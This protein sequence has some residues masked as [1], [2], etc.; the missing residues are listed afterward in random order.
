VISAEPAKAT[1][2]VNAWAVRISGFLFGFAPGQT[3]D[4]ESCS[5]N[6]IRMPGGTRSF[7]SQFLSTPAADLTSEIVAFAA[8][9]G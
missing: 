2:N 8:R 6:L 3:Q 1:A 9:Q 4:K 7:G 5:G